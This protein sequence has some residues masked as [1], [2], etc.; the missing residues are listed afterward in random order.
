MRTDTDSATAFLAALHPPGSIYCVCAFAANG[1]VWQQH[2]S[3][4]EEGSDLAAR[5]DAQARHEGVYA[6]VANLREVPKRGRGAESDVSDAW[7]A[8]A[9]IDAVDFEPLAG[10]RKIREQRG[11]KAKA[12]KENAWKAATAEQREAAMSAARKAAESLPIGPPSALVD[13]G[14][15]WHPYWLLREAARDLDLLRAVNKRIAALA[16]G[17]KCWDLARV[18]KVPGTHNRKDPGAPVASRLVAFDPGA[19]HD[20]DELAA[21]LGIPPGSGQ[22]DP[23][24]APER[25]E[26]RA[27]EAPSDRPPA[28]LPAVAERVERARAYVAKMPPAVQGNRGSDAAFAVAER[29]TRGFAVPRA[30]AIAIFAGDYNPRCEPPWSGKE[31]EHKIDSAL[32]RGRRELGY[33]L[34]RRNG[35]SQ[36]D[37]DLAGC[38]ASFSTSSIEAMPSAEA[39]YEPET[40]ADLA[41]IYDSAPGEYGRIRILLEERFGR[42]LHVRDLERALDDDIRRSKAGAT[43]SAQAREHG[44][45]SRMFPGAPLPPGL[46]M[47]GPYHVVPGKGIVREIPTG[48][49]NETRGEVICDVPLFV[50]GRSIDLADRS[51][52]TTVAWLRDETWSSASIP[53]SRLAARRYIVEDLAE[54]G[55]SVHSENAGEIVAYLSRFE[56]ANLPVLPPSFS[57]SGMGWLRDD[58]G[59]VGFLLGKSLIAPRQG[60]PE[61]VFRGHDAGDDQVASALKTRGAFDGWKKAAALAAPYPRV[62][63]AV[64]ASLA[65]PLLAALDAE[66]FCVD[67]AAQTSTGKSTCLKLGASVWGV[68]SERNGGLIRGWDNTRVFSECLSATLNHLPTF[69]DDT[70]RARDPKQVAQTIYDMTS[71]GGRGRGTVKGIARSRTFHTVL[72]STGESQVTAL[73][74]DGGLKARVLSLW[75]PPFGS[76]ARETVAAI[77]AGCAENYGWAGRAWVEWLAAHR[78]EVPDWKAERSETIERYASSAPEC[79]AAGRLAEHVSMIDI[80]MRLSHRA[81]DLSWEANPD[82]IEAVWRAAL[83]GAKD[84]DVARTALVTAVGWAHSHAA[85]FWERNSTASD[86]TP[87][88]PHGGWS[89]RWSEDPRRGYVGFFP[90]RL[91][92][93]LAGAGHGYEVVKVWRDRGW[94][95][96]SSDDGLSFRAQIN[97]RLAR[98][99]A[100]RLDIAQTVGVGHDDEKQSDTPPF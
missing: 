37:D 76:S 49:E 19:R 36:A 96:V 54:K 56:T 40:R 9:D 44:S 18:L 12:A 4:P 45:P 59:P 92:E 41:R 11:E 39:V 15:G 42:T 22:P 7:A 94:L 73:T 50:S 38:L 97:G 67:W 28:E 95:H 68:P 89:G 20:L 8:W 85:T 57:S 64:Y 30:E 24:A 82:V 53:R 5:T 93:V 77:L 23:K 66:N 26:D 99:I 43:R 71:G 62:I 79:G 52:V 31:I 25:A 63:L 46:V 16:G 1:S 14:R 2:A 98:I 29:I 70:K 78:D 90:F 75:G 3:T 86:G 58:K 60:A 6:T 34:N 13:S 47:T 27:Q 87:V 88:V 51:E 55:L 74:N 48:E 10:M 69:G 84:A 72:L 61:V 100:I 81:L 33:L 65:P 83:D 80:T 32:T 91:A 21:K 17:D 35:S